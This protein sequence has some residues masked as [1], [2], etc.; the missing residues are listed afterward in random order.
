[1]SSIPLEDLNEPFLEPGPEG[2]TGDGH[3]PDFKYLATLPPNQKY[4][5]QFNGQQVYIDSVDWRDSKLMKFQVV[6]ALLTFILFGLGDQ[7]I[8]TIIPKLQEQYHIGDLQT[9]FIF[10]SSTAGYFILALTCEFFQRSF[11]VRG[12]GIIGTGCLALAFFIISTHPPFW[13]FIVCYMINGIGLGSLDASVNGW[14]GGIA[15]SNQILGIVHGCYGLGCMISPPLITKLMERKHN[16]WNWNHYYVVL[17]IYGVINLVCFTF[18]F[19]H[20]TAAKHKFNVILK[21]QKRSLADKD[22]EFEIG[23]GDESVEDTVNEG[24]DVS[25]TDALKSKLVWVF[26][27]CLFIYVGGEVAFGA[28]LMTFL[29]RIKKLSYNYSSWMAT[30]FWLGLTVGRIALGFVT[31]HV[32]NTELMA[33]L[34]YIVASLAGYLIFCL[35]AF[36]K[37]NWILFPIV[38]I[39]GLFVGPIFPTTIVASIEILPTRY[40]ATSVGFICAFGG[41]GA[42]A[43]PFLVGF[44]AD[45]SKLG[46]KAHPFIVFALYLILLV[47]WAGICKRYAGHKRRG[48]L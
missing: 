28:W 22:P 3:G 34:A 48:V 37:A 7:T 25:F 11:G 44:V 19:R 17:S 10:L 13:L 31:A 18:S 1:M 32:F 26:A 21:E 40:H 27:I 35:F 4:V 15:D 30:T 43:L 12:V 2:S 33:N 6:V 20:E 39:T 23:S 24:T 14:V 47:L 42:A 45:H 8:G 9:S 41:G 36:S 5:T 29:I 16:P 46:M 38:F